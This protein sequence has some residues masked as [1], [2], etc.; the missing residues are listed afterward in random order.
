M[1]IHTFCEAY[2]ELKDKRII[3]FGTHGGSGIGSYTTKLKGHFPEAKYLEALGIAGA[4]IRETA[5]RTTV[6]NWLKK[7]GFKKKTKI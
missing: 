4:S 7:L 5:I 2:P 6:E 1:I 3:P